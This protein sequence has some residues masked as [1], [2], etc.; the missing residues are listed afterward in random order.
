MT[1]KV[2]GN[3]KES[4]LPKVASTPDEKQEDYWYENDNT[5]EESSALLTQMHQMKDTIQTLMEIN[6]D[7]HWKIVELTNEKTYLVRQIRE[8][9]RELQ[10]LEA[11]STKQVMKNPA[12]EGE[13]YELIKVTPK[14]FKRTYTAFIP[15]NARKEETKVPN[16]TTCDIELTDRIKE[17]MSTGVSARPIAVPFTYDNFGG[18]LNGERKAKQEKNQS[19]Q[20]QA[21]ANLF[22]TTT[23]EQKSQVGESELPLIKKLENDLR[24]GVC[25]NNVQLLTETILN[26]KEKKMTSLIDLK[27]A[28]K[29]LK[30]ILSQ[31]ATV[32]K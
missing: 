11:E 20:Y 25:N 17:L 2:I 31:P 14:Q 27:P 19:S 32:T 28:E 5:A 10:H 26:I 7:Q 18:S 13:A 30:E 8:L 15:K 6:Q 4:P 16:E 1:A 3:E 12:I 24:E 22:A 21:L 9:T 23:V 29:K